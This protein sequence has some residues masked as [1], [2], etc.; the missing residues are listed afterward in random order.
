MTSIN[1]RI[2]LLWTHQNCEWDIVTQP[3]K[4]DKIDRCLV[5]AYD[6]IH[7]RLETNQF[8]FCMSDSAKKKVWHPIGLQ[9]PDSHDRL[10]EWQLN[11]HDPQFWL[12]FGALFWMKYTATNS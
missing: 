9:S 4:F 1:D 5:Q 6:V 7:R 2:L 11:V 12:F 10:S 8:I 3:R